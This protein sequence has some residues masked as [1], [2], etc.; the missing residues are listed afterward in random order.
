MYISVLYSNMFTYI[1]LI[2]ITYLPVYVYRVDMLHKYHIHTLCNSINR[3]VMKRRI[4]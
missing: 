1:I 4:Q 2:S 3:Y